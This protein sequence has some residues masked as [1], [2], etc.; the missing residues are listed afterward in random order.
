MFSAGN[1]DDASRVNSRKFGGRMASLTGANRPF[2]D[3]TQAGIDVMPNLTKDSGTGGRLAMIP[4]AA[5][6]PG[7]IGAGIGALT[8]DDDRTGGAEMGGTI[9][10]TGYLGALALAG[11]THSKTGQ[12]VIQKALLADRPD[13][14]IKIGDAMMANPKYAGMFG[15]GGARSYFLNPPLAQ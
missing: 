14:L 5:A 2:Y 1:L 15:A 8:N 11:L 4:L 13:I 10:S 7:S 12:K 9:G 6:I 3:L